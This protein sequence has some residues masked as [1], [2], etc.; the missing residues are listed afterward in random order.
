MNNPNGFSVA[1]TF[2]V[3][4]GTRLV[5]RLFLHYYFVTTLLWQLT[6]ERAEWVSFIQTQLTSVVVAHGGKVNSEGIK[7]GGGGTSPRITP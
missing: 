3:F 1:K 6:R 7:C 4:L 2:A 5:S